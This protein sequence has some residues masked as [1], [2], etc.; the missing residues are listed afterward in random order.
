LFLSNYLL[1]EIDIYSSLDEENS[2]VVL[3]CLHLLLKDL[4]LDSL[5]NGGG[6][7]GGPTPP[8]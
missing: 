5:F 2:G 6:G 7:G 1:N 8:P 4:R 3:E